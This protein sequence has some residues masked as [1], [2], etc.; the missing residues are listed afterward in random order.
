MS[1]ILNKAYICQGIS[2]EDILFLR[3]FKQKIVGENL[4]TT[5]VSK[6]H[7]SFIDKFIKLM[8]LLPGKSDKEELRELEKYYSFGTIK[9]GLNICDIAWLQQASATPLSEHRNI[10]LLK[11]I[12]KKL[13][14]HFE[15]N[16]TEKLPY[17]RHVQSI[18]DMHTK[19]LNPSKGNRMDQLWFYQV[20]M[21]LMTL[22]KSLNS[23]GN[24]EDR[25]SFGDW[26]SGSFTGNETLYPLYGK[27][28]VELKKLIESVQILLAL[29]WELSVDPLIAS[30]LKFNQP[31]YIFRDILEEKNEL[32]ILSLDGGGVRGKIAAAILNDLTQRVR[33][34][35]E[36]FSVSNFFHYMGGTSVGGL[37]VI[38]LN[39]SNPRGKASF[40]EEEIAQMFDQTQ[41]ERIFPPKSESSKKSAQANSYAYSPKNIEKFLLA[42][43]GYDMLSHL[44]KPTLVMTHSNRTQKTDSIAEL[45]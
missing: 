10:D 20:F 21:E 40:T 4:Q 43:Y 16:Y 5:T 38:A 15:I 39:K 2:T 7:I 19:L 36:D 9:R 11:M 35:R 18:K 45:Q 27:E 8:G 44:V 34:K 12:Q 25:R 23:L 28:V 6:K 30:I 37:I 42:H 29:K 1:E 26:L 24:A 31:E 32:W 17:Y 22:K 41:T 33:T 3:E 13:N 14:S